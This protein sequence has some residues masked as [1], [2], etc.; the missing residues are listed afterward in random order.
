MTVTDTS[1]DHALVVGDKKNSQT[2]QKPP[3]GAPSEGYTHNG[4]GEDGQS[5]MVED[6]GNVRPFTP[7]QDSR[8]VEQPQRQQANFVERSDNAIS[9]I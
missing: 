3:L 2:A 4:P 9:E 7:Q 5:I 1:F 8:Q 6:F